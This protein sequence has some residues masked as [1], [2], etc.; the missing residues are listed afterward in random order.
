MPRAPLARIALPPAE[1][2]SDAFVATFERSL[3]AISRDVVPLPFSVAFHGCVADDLNACI[4]SLGPVSRFAILRGSAGPVLIGMPDNVAAAVTEFAFGG[5]GSDDRA[6]ARAI[7]P[8]GHAC[9]Q[10]LIEQLAT[11]LAPRLGGASIEKFGSD[12]AD[13]VPLTVPALACGF[14][15]Q[16]NETPLGAIG[17]IV[18][19]AVVAALENAAGSGESSAEWS[20]QLAQSIAQARVDLRAVLA[21]PT[22]SAQAVANLRPGSVIPIP[23]LTEVALIAEGYRIATGTA[24]AQ[25]GRATVVITR[26]EFAA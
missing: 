16:A 10:R 3:G 11:A 17:V 5:D 13:V 15:L 14:S 25:D 20:A 4:A 8:I 23:T 21:R 2:P 7:S 1:R 19:L 26:T 9:S 12:L 24:D 22:L 18:P 6:A